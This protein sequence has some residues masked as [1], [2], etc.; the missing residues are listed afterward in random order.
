MGNCLTR[1]GVEAGPWFIR[2]DCLGLQASTFRIRPGR[3]HAE[4]SAVPWVGFTGTN[5]VACTWQGAGLDRILPLEPLKH[6]ETAV[7]DTCLRY[8]ESLVIYYR[9]S[10]QPSPICIQTSVSEDQGTLPATPEASLTPAKGQKAST[11]DS[12]FTHKASRF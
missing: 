8:L 11:V 10:P 2:P 12:Y 1:S 4:G 9:H 5:N 7:D 6:D 3:S